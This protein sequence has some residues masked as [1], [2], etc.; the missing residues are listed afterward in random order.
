MRIK[1]QRMALAGAAALLL[2]GL[3]PQCNAQTPGWGPGMMGGPGPYPQG[4][5]GGAGMGPWMMNGYGPN[6]Q[7]PGN[8]QTVLA[9]RL[10]VLKQELKITG[11]QESAWKAYADA[12]TTADQTLLSSMHSAMQSATAAP[13]SPDSRFAFMSQMIALQKQAYDDEKKAAEALLPKL[14]AYQSGQASMVL[15]GLAQTSGG[16]GGFGMGPWMMGY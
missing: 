2:A 5:M 15:P 11:D 14:T 13:M 7:Q 3:A 8:G 9:H 6:D 12:V 10:D 4:M 16:Y 1:F